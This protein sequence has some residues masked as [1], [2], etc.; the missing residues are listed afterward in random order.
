MRIT[1][2]DELN[3]LTEMARLEWDAAQVEKDETGIWLVR[4]PGADSDLLGPNLT[5]ARINLTNRLSAILERRGAA[6][7]RRL[8]RGLPLR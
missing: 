2:E 7:V 5:V 4:F 1:D 6:Q 8:G 3:D